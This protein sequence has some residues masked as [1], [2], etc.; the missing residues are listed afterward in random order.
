MTF[1]FDGM[2]GLGDSI[3]QRP[4]LRHHPGCYVRTPW[5]ELYQDLDV[6]CVRSCTPL[7]T[8]RKH[9]LSALER[10]HHLPS[11]IYRRRIGYGPRELAQGGIIT[12]FRNQ[13]GV[14]GALQFDLPHFD[15]W[16][17][18]LP[19]NRKIAVIR[20]AT[21]RTEWD[22]ANRNPD[23]CYLYTAA[24]EL[25]QRGFFVVSLAD[26]EPG[27]EWI[28][29]AAPPADLQFHA[30][31]LTLTQLCTLYARASCVVAPVGFS[32]PMAIASGTP[33]FVVAGGRGGHNAPEIVTSPDMECSRVR[34]ALPDNYCRC[35]RADHDCSKAISD[36]D[37]LFK[38]WI[39]E[40]I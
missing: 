27:K 15:D 40:C 29:G 9:E 31:E 18:R 3:Y 28:V 36:F 33:L 22:G 26:L 38:G 6:R 4:F 1:L 5:P 2:M 32:V 30:G 16:H 13:F 21:V 10:Y 11:G 23:P 19:D 14:T 35:T 8:Q 12:A 17:P 37:T 7:R 25:R 39:D 24:N 34:W 20:P